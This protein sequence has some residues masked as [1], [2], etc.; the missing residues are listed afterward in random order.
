MPVSPPF[1]LGLGSGSGSGSAAVPSGFTD[2][3]PSSAPPAPPPADVPAAHST[4]LQHTLHV[5]R[6]LERSRRDA[7]TPD[8]HRFP[9][10]HPLHAGNPLPPPTSDG[11]FGHLPAHLA[12]QLAALPPLPPPAHQRHSR[13]PH[14][15]P[16]PSV[17]FLFVF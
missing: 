16:A 13:R 1:G 7:H 11:Q 12:A 2:P 3:P 14:A 6:Q 10:P 8:H 15:P 4:S 9:F 5:A 17:S